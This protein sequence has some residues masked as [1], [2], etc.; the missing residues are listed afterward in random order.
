MHHQYGQSLIRG[1][2]SVLFLLCT[3]PVLA[4]QFNPPYP[5]IAAHA[6]GGGWYKADSTSEARLE[7]ISRFH[8]ANLGLQR[9]WTNNGYNTATLTRK[10]KTLNP[11]I[12]LFHVASLVQAENI[13]LTSY[14]HYYIKKKIESEKG[15]NGIGDW[16]LYK[17][18]GSH[19]F[20][21]GN[22][23]NL[24]R[25]NFLET[26]TPDRFGRTFPQWY[27]KYL[28]APTSEGVDF[29]STGVGMSEGDWDGV[30]EDDQYISYSHPTM[31]I[32]TGDWDRD[33][34]AENAYD[35]DL[36]TWIMNGHVALRDAVKAEN[37]NHWFIGNM[38]NLFNEQTIP[39]DYRPNDGG[40][41]EEMSRYEATRGWAG[42]MDRYRKGIALLN[43]SGPKIGMMHN[44]INIIRGYYPDLNY[45]Q[46]RWNRY[47]L[48]SAL[49]EDAFYIVSDMAS[50][51]YSTVM[52]FDEFWGGDL[53]K[54]GFLGYPKEPPQTAPKEN[55][56]FIREF[57]NGLVIVNPGGNGRRSVNV[58]SGWRRI[59]GTQ[60]PTHNSGEAVQSLSLDERDGIILV[61]SNISRP[62]SP[63]NLIVE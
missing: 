7:L 26:V 55:G 46:E 37:S 14:S 29:V 30:Y 36:R 61:R 44:S 56:L 21:W 52:W 10:L 13:D 58:G 4:E 59:R 18:D 49:M 40:F 51:G 20:G 28:Y 32:S 25:I 45:T 33:G 39:A 2:A 63:S 35:E 11:E 62:L 1:V 42:M 6:M 38:V 54:V 53:K 17:P 23:E 16:W 3:S 5:R 12:R 8:I 19:I 43:P 57:D 34:T 60:D 47:F 41:F 22:R 24:W 27:A 9:R 48:S 31:G 50:G 15:P